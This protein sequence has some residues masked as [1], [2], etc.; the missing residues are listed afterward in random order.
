MSADLAR[1][2]PASCGAVLA[3]LAARGNQHTV[4]DRRDQFRRN[5]QRG[6]PLDDLAA[7]VLRPSWRV[8]ASER[9]HNEIAGDSLARPTR[10]YDVMASFAQELPQHGD[11]G[12]VEVV[13]GQGAPAG[14]P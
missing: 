8:T 4:T 11:F 3:C 13:I 10:W 7:Q 5:E 6:E 9:Q 14:S 1:R 12:D 2:R